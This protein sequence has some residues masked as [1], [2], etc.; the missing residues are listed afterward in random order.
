MRRLDIAARHVFPAATTFLILILL[1]G[2]LGLPGQSAAEPAFALASV[3]FWSLYRPVA[4]GPLV[5]FGLGLFCDLIGGGVPGVT[6]LVLLAV[7]AVA[8]HWRRELS[9]QGFGVLWLVFL[10][11][12]AGAVAI[13]WAISSALALRLLPLAVPALVFGLAAG[14]YPGL[15]VLFIRAHR[16]LAAP[17]RA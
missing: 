12:A 2:P 1:A 15:A 5:V 16:S 14:A 17:E 11:V 13:F 8:L 10:A 4:M 9:R 3:F 6:V 7:H